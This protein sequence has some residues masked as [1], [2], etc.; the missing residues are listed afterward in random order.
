[1]VAADR[2]HRRDRIQVIQDVNDRQIAGMQDQVAPGQGLVD[3]RR[4]G[5]EI[6]SHVGVGNQPDAH[7][8]AGR[9]DHLRSARS[10]F[11]RVTAAWTR[12]PTSS[13]YGIPAAA[14]S[15]G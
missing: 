14:I 7:G 8:T 3:P 15:D 6:L 9:G 2:P 4:H 13:E 5:V 10:R 1:M 12:R 11:A